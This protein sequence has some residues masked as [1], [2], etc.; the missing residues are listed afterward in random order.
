MWAEGPRRERWPPPSRC[1]V[2]GG[3]LLLLL[4]LPVGLLG[5]EVDL[6]SAEVPE[7]ALGEELLRIGSLDGPD[8]AFVG[9]GQVTLDEEGRIYVLDPRYP[10]LKVFDPD[11]GFSHQIGRAGDGP[12]EYRVPGPFG[13]L[14]DTVWIG[15]QNSGT[16][17]FFLRDGSALDAVTL[18]GEGPGSAPPSLMRVHGRSDFLVATPSGPTDLL[19]LGPGPVQFT[20]WLVRRGRDAAPQ[21]TVGSYLAQPGL[22]VL[23]GGSALTY[24]RISDAPLLGYV[25]D[26]DLVLEV[27]RPIASTPEEGIFRVT[28]RDRAGGQSSSRSFRYRPVEIPPSSRDSLMA[29]V[30]DR[31]PDGSEARA[32]V[33]QASPVPRFLPPVTSLRRSGATD[34]LWVSREWMQGVVPHRRYAALSEDLRLLATLELPPRARLVGQYDDRS[35]WVVERDEFD[36]E[37]LVR[38]ELIAAPGPG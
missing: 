10:A 32:V 24:P 36:V 8:D 21:D 3:L 11:G 38:Y 4:V 33:E 31:V 37:T 28:A 7:W 22:M 2:H 18:Q 25:A 35:I 27:E 17:S 1:S 9:I 15:D 12:G 6:D 26:R 13:L 30:L 5:Q 16:I 14:G 23:P 34:M 19:D 20:Q 29:V